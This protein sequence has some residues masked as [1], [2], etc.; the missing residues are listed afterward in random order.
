MDQAIAAATAGGQLAGIS[1]FCVVFTDHPGA[2]WAFW[3]GSGGRCYVDML[4]PL[5]VLAMENLHV[6]TQ[7]ADLYGIQESPGAF[8]VMDCS[9][10][11]HPSAFTKLSFGWMDPGMVATLPAG[12]GTAN[13]TVHA[14][15]QPLSSAPT[16]GRVH[17]V[18]L[19][20][21]MGSAYHLVEARLRTDRYE[22]ATP[23]VSNGIPDEGVVIYWIDEST[24][25]PVHFR[26]VLTNPGATYADAASGIQVT[27]SAS[28]PDGFS[29]A[30][31]RTP[32]AECA[33]IRDE[34]AGLGGRDPRPASRSPAGRTGG[35]GRAG[36]SDQEAA[37]PGV[38]AAGAGPAT[39][40]PFV[41]RAAQSPAAT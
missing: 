33:W 17:A 23:N 27:L 5:G 30:I 35:E 2:S 14:V 3:G 8:D 31:D 28:V 20:A 34:L 40:L 18:K 12:S 29:V 25:P 32:P 41:S 1:Y 37:D 21:P 36:G 13:L 9:C 16:P 4:V 26:T 7:F 15:S 24:W 6:L 10:G 19:P 11:T 38:K 22:T 39:G